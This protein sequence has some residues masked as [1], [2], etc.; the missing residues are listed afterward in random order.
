MKGEERERKKMGENG[1]EMRG[2]GR[3]RGNREFGGVVV[4][5]IATNVGFCAKNIQQ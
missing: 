1:R 5:V 4:A 2:R 3:G